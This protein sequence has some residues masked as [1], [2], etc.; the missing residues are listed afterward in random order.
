MR[1]VFSKE[2]RERKIRFTEAA[3]RADLGKVYSRFIAEVVVGIAA[4]GS[5]RL[6]E[7]GRT[8]E[9]DIPLHATRK[10]LSRNLANERIESVIGKK[11]LA[12]GAES[13]GDDSLLVVTSSGLRKKY[14]ESMEYLGVVRG[15]GGEKES[16]GYSL[17]EVAGWDLDSNKVTPLAE[18]LWSQNAPEAMTESQQVL[19]LV[20][21]VRAATQGRGIIVHQSPGDPRELLLPWTRDP[22]CRYLASLRPDCELIYRKKAMPCWELG[23]LCA[24]P[25]SDMVRKVYEKGQEHSA[26]VHFGF[27]PVRLPGHPE[28]P[29][30]LVVE[31]S[32][33]GL[34]QCILTTEPMRRNRGVLQWAIDAFHAS[35]TAEVTMRLLKQRVD[36]D[37]IRVLKYRRLRNMA[38]LV[39]FESFYHVE[40]AP[41][42]RVSENSVRFHSCESV[43]PSKLLS[44]ATP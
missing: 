20:E 42:F 15:D 29:L 24:F 3:F 41:D 39:L 10:R 36:F 13:I 44:A 11:I 14:A 31:K 23:H 38:A 28:R 18:V 25:Y 2:E 9:E 35:W 43:P 22:A 17:C 32:T 1:L 5:V 40:R 6:T 7:I 19:A 33:D 16:R 4:S 26:L 27:L 37:D 34:L 8:L 21:R 12:L 30:W